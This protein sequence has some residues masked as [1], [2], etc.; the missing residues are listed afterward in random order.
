MANT[1]LDREVKLTEKD[2]KIAISAK[3]TEK[4]NHLVRDVVAAKRKQSTVIPNWM[5]V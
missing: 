3:P 4:Y 5:K 2:A 1:S